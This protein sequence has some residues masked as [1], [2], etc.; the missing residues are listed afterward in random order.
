[1]S[2]YELALAR[3]NFCAY[4]QLRNPANVELA[5]LEL[6]AWRELMAAARAAQPEGP[7]SRA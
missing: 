3:W 4:E 2:R 7:R 6:L 5:L 1:M